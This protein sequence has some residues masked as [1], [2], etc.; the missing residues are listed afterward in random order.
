MDNNSTI[1]ND[2]EEKEKLKT[3]RTLTVLTFIGC[4][5]VYI[6]AIWGFAAADSRYQQMQEAID[7]GTVAKLPGFLQ[8]MYTPEKLAQ[9]QKMAENK[10]PLLII[11]LICTSLCLFGAIQMRKLKADGYWMW[12]IGEILPYFGMA[13]FVGIGSVTGLFNFIGYAIIAVFVILYS[14]QRKYL[15]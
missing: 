12:L 11:N 5:L 6:F 4:G 1:F 8:S 9:M 10:V 15:K 14:M 3:L 7:N 2:L 13:F